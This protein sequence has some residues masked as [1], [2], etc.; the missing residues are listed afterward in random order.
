MFLYRTIA[1]MAAIAIFLPSLTR[2]AAIT[3]NPDEAAS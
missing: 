3:I 1:T 2:A